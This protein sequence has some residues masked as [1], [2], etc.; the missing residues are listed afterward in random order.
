MS[1]GLLL[2]SCF[3]QDTS[4]PA[5]GEPVPIEEERHTAEETLKLYVAALRET[6]VMEFDPPAGEQRTVITGYGRIRDVRIEGR[7]LYFITNNTYGRGRPQQNDD[8]LYRI[9]ISKFAD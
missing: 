7:H 8:K 6:A 9:P 5:P 2:T 4:Y 1:V 3:A